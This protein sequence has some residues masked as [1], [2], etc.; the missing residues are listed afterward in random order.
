MT[1]FLFLTLLLA[2]LAVVSAAPGALAQSPRDYY[3]LED[4]IEDLEKQIRT[5]Q[6]AAAQGK[7]DDIEIT[8]TG[9][10][11]QAALLADMEI[12]ISQLQKEMSEL[13]GQ[14]EEILYKQRQLAEELEN[15]RRDVEFRFQDAGA[16]MIPG[17]SQDASLEAG[18]AQTLPAAEP[19]RVAAVSVLPQGSVQD[20]YDFS[21]S[22]LRKG[23][24]AGAER[25]FAEFM[26][27]HPDHALSGNAQYW[28]GETHY[29][30]KNYP[31]AA[32]AFLTGFQQYQDSNKGPDNLLKLGM[33]LAAMGQVDEACTAFAELEAVYPGAPPVIVS[34]T[35][36]QKERYG[37][38]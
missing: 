31:Q 20:Q 25:A 30:R 26:T 3:E 17:P 2:A 14:N 36:A 21:F 19:Q 1:R 9:G 33:S 35:G 5:L 10:A 24:Y 34:K 38:R 27:K 11:D 16:G 12:R 13:R 7:L 18:E 37:C 23:D 6:R 4:R 29:V 15:F 32:A 28:L 8:G 22:L